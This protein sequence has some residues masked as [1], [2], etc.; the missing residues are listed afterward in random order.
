M[1]YAV[2]LQNVFSAEILNNLISVKNMLQEYL[3]LNV[4]PIKFKELLAQK[5][6]LG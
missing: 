6:E 1:S 3:T 5:R 2:A 4:I